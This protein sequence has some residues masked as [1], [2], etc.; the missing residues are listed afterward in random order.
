[1]DV[2]IFSS[3]ALSW[4]PYSFSYRARARAI[5]AAPACYFRCGGEQP[6]CGCSPPP[7]N[8]NRIV[9]TSMSAP[10]G[11]NRRGLLSF[12]Q[13]KKKGLLEKVL[14]IEQPAARSFLATHYIFWR[15]IYLGVLFLRTLGL[16]RCYFEKY[17]CVPIPKIRRKLKSR[18]AWPMLVLNHR[19]AKW[20]KF[21]KF[22]KLF[23]PI[24]VN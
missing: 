3:V 18:T 12:Y 21:S 10:C 4:R 1:M 17:D 15:T 13:L 2:S 20:L 7:R 5:S 6:R 19:Q 11:N 16:S 22:K 23:M 14:R 8:S 9:T 24:L